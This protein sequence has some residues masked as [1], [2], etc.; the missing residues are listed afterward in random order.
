MNPLLEAPWVKTSIFRIDW[1][2]AGDQ[3]VGADF[4]GNLFYHLH[5]KFPGTTKDQKYSAMYQEID[6]YYVDEDVL[7]R[8]DTL[9]PTF[10]ESKNGMKLRC[11]AAK[12]RQLVPFA[13]RLATEV[14][15]LTNPVEHAI[16]LA[17]YH[18]KEVYSTLSSTCID[19]DAK[20]K[21]H[22]PKFALQYVALHDQLNESDSRLWRIKPKMHMFMHLCGEGGEP[23]KYWCYRDEDFGGSVAKAARRRGG[24]LRPK[25]TSSS[26]LMCFSILTPRVS[27]R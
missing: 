5:D 6:Q 15:D 13:F 2:H 20:M 16:Y 26:V 8:L 18:L 12:V 22:G 4:V 9:K 19:A 11:S 17:A 7:D 10:V 3:G 21:E 24:L 25:S 1:L 27:L 23:G 14:C